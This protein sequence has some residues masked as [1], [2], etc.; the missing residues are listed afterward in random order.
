MKIC[1]IEKGPA[2][3]VPRFIYLKVPINAYRITRTFAKL[4]DN[5]L[6]VILPKRLPSTTNVFDNMSYFIYAE[7]KR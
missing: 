5:G 6:H 7:Q 4:Y 3:N 1:I 2:I